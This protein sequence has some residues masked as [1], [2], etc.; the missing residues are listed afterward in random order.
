MEGGGCG[1]DHMVVEFTSICAISAIID[2]NL[3]QIAKGG[4]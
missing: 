3:T 4:L 1:R 2:F